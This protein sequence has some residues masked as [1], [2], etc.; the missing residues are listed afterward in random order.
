M[1]QPL[2][3]LLYTIFMVIASNIMG[4]A[5]LL[6]VIFLATLSRGERV[7]RNILRIKNTETVQ[8]MNDQMKF[9]DIAEKVG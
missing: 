7:L 2:H 1:I 5:P 6:A 8:S 3:A 4:E 9:K